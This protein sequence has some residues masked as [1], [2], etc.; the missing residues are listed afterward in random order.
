MLN[1]RNFLKRFLSI[2]LLQQWK[3]ALFT[4]KH[5]LWQQCSTDYSKRGVKITW[6]FHFQN[7]SNKFK[8]IGAFTAAELLFLLSLCTVEQLQGAGATKKKK[9][10]AGSWS[11]VIAP[12]ASEKYKQAWL[13]LY[14]LF[15]NVQWKFT[16][17]S[18]TSPGRKRLGALAQLKNEALRLYCHSA[19]TTWTRCARPLGHD[20]MK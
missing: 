19:T 6:Y 8:I 16:I 14:L 1:S 15:Q 4:C 11:E 20:T 10:W 18:Y 13:R 17:S 7:T 9:Q 12:V 2:E 3:L 5:L